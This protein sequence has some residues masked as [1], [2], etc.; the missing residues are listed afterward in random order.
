MV[1]NRNNSSEFS[2][3]A[4]RRFLLGRLSASEQPA[5]EKQLFSSTL[6]DAR[7][8]LAELDL[9]DDYAYGRISAG[10]RDLCEEKFL[11]NSD[12]R[13]EVEVSI[14]LRDRFASIG[15]TK[16]TVIAGVRPL[17]RLNR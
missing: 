8:R 4:I 5:F 3:E 2:D 17:L 7:V 15:N 9:A 10:E 16:P 13:R 6:L 1:E 12:R 14:A 11:V